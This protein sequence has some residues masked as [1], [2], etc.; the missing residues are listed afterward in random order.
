MRVRG[1][2]GGSGWPGRRPDVGV[3]IVTSAAADW[4]A[5]AAGTV[6]RGERLDE[7]AP[8]S[9][10]GLSIVDELA[11]AYRGALNLSDSGLGGLKVELMLPRAES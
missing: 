7:N 10:L 2:A 9:G 6:R 4:A 11:R 3:A 5:A 8:G 1:L